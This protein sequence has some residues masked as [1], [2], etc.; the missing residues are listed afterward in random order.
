M[1]SFTRLICKRIKRS[2][3][4]GRIERESRNRRNLLDL[5]SFPP[6]KEAVEVMLI[7]PESSEGRKEWGDVEC[8]FGCDQS[9]C[10][11]QRHQTLY[12]LSGT[13]SGASG[14]WAAVWP[15][16]DALQLPSF[17]PHP[18]LPSPDPFSFSSNPSNPSNPSNSPN[19]SERSNP[20]PSPRCPAFSL[21][22]CWTTYH[23]LG[24]LQDSWRR[25]TDSW[26]IAL[27]WAL[28]WSAALW[29]ETLTILR[30]SVYFRW[31]SFAGSS[32]FLAWASY[33][34]GILHHPSGPTATFA[35]LSWSFEAEEFF[36]LQFLTCN[37]WSL[38]QDHS[39]R[40]TQTIVTV[41]S[42]IEGSFLFAFPF[43]ILLLSG[44]RPRKSGKK[45]LRRCYYTETRC[46]ANIHFIG[47]DS[48]ICFR[49]CFSSVPDIL[50]GSHSNS[51]AFLNILWAVSR[52]LKI[53]RELFETLL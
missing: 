25:F 5:F 27:L 42:V 20:L 31:N 39:W 40:R 37:F 53:V 6:K 2:Q 24:L 28:L 16:A 30:G 9:S 44:I 10:E 41:G 48:L 17:L 32:W 13:A 14:A 45:T 22:A 3:L 49:H 19:F 38:F 11:M 47:P 23:Y 15:R 29:T 4:L 46:C 8:V 50:R 1:H 35:I 43:F 52:W 26:R 12:F 18:G 21:L 51:R 33:S 7:L 34:S 36:N